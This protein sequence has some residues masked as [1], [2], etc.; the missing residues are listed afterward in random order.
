MRAT[1]RKVKALKVRPGSA[2][3]KYF[4]VQLLERRQACG[5]SQ[6]ELARIASC[7]TSHISQLERGRRIP[8][9]GNIEAIAKALRVSDPRAMFGEVTEIYNVTVPA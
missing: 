5:F 4:A 2:L 7:S 8:S 1:K 6:E 9:L 3:A